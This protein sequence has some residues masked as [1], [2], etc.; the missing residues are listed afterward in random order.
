MFEEPLRTPSEMPHPMT[1]LLPRKS[2]LHLCPRLKT[3]HLRHAV[4]NLR[5]VFPLLQY[6][7]TP[8]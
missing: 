2:R 8:Y 5:F 1:Q 3:A 7:I 4:R 6:I